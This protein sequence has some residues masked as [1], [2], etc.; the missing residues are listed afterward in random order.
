MRTRRH[1]G[2]LLFSTL[3]IWI[4]AVL[5]QDAASRTVLKQVLG[6]SLSGGMCRAYDGTTVWHQ[7][8]DRQEKFF[9]KTLVIVHV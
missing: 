3:I 5:D 8:S 7:A 1:K 9:S 4:L 6:G 2:C